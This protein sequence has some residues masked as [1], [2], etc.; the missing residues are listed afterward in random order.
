MLKIALKIDPAY[1]INSNPASEDYLIPTEVT[2][3]E[4][5][6]V[7]VGKVVYPRGEKKKFAFSAQPLSV[8]EGEIEITVPLSVSAAQQGVRKLLGT[9]RY[10]ACND[11]SCLI[12][13]EI[14][15]KAEIRV[16]TGG[17]SQNPLPT[18]GEDGASPV[19]GSPVAQGT[20]TSDAE[21][22]QRRYDVKGL[23]T[24]VFL[25]ASGR[26]RTDLRAGEELTR[27]SMIAKLAALQSGEKLEVD[28]RGAAGW[29]ARLQESDL[30]LQL[31]LVFVGGLALNLTP[32]VYPMIPITIGYFGA[33]SEGR[34]GKTF[35]L[36]LLY[37][38]GLAI[39]YSALGIF[40]AS[41]GSLFGSALQSPYVVG[42]VAV[43]LFVLALGM[44]GLFTIQ[45]PQFLM[46]R[47]GAKKGAL[48][49][50]SMGALLGIVAAPCVGPIV[51]ALLTYVG[52]EGNV[53]KGF[54]LF[55]TLSMGLG[56][57]YLLLGAFSGAIKSMPRSGMWLERSKKI[58]AVPLI[59][60]ALFYGYSAVN[61]LSSS[62]ASSGAPK[63][64]ERWPLAT[65]TSIESARAAKRP[66]VLD[67]RADWCLPCLELEEKV[68][69]QSDVKAAAKGVDLRQ[70]DLTRA[71][72]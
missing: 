31:L 11:T 19:Q 48:G 56:L 29:M 45:P 55:F 5:P 37:V 30:W 62:S 4:A 44:F 14:P 68:F 53:W 54:A 69:S 64:S 28:R 32:C 10:Q 46:S 36:A 3:D 42:F 1:H 6:G 39:V 26:E 24:I 60:A 66:V 15:I 18:A 70:V 50:L 8:Y 25:D 2:L 47:S 34:I 43:V 51:A 38:L 71:T 13:T 7:E 59:I 35:G 20:G 61:L 40:A 21:Q 16:G 27:E 49:A 58:F 52:A 72:S 23:P 17:V 33:Q 65:L 12:P 22:L 57:P 63:A 41:T 9:V 67:F